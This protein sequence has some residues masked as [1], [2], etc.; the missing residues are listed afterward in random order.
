[1]VLAKYTNKRASRAAMIISTKSYS[2]L[3][4]STLFRLVLVASLGID[5]LHLRCLSMPNR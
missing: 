4:I 3:S 2:N 5:N 1:M